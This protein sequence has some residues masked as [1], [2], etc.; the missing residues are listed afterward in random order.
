MAKLS[1]A[2]NR[3]TS[4]ETLTELA[5]DPNVS[6]RQRVARNPHTPAKA[7]VKL[8]EDEEMSVRYYVARNPHTPAKALVKLAEDKDNQNTRVYAADNPN[9]P[10]AVHLWLKIGGFAGMTLAEFVDKVNNDQTCES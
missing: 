1:K 10:K 8:A 3:R 2:E 7:L 9:C 6:V 4:V 5:N